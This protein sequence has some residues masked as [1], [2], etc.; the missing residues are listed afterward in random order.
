MT[1]PQR[2]LGRMIAFVVVV[3]LIAGALV[4]ELKSAFLANAALNGVILGVLILGIAYIIRQVILLR[5]EVDW[6]ETYRRN[7]PGLSVQ[8]SP[9]LLAPMAAML[10]ERAGRISLSAPSMRSLLD[11]ISSRMDESRDTSRYL[12]GLLIFLGLLGTFW[13]LLETIGSI[14]TTVRNMSLSSG[15]FET[16]FADL[17][18]GL[19]APLSGMATAFSS[20]L[21]GL[22]GSLVLGFLDLQAG[23]AQNRFYMDLEE[24]LSS[25]TR[26]SSGGVGEGD[27]SVPAY[28]SALLEQTAD[29]LDSLQR[30]IGRGEDSRITA[31]STLLQLAEKLATLSDQMRTEQDLMVKLAESQMELKPV[32]GRLA[33]S[34]ELAADRGLDEMSRSHLKN[35]DVYVM[36]LLEET[37][38]GRKELVED[39]RSEIKLLTRTLAGMAEQQRRDR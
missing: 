33:Q 18:R 1:R 29:S 31:N 12:I 23:Q 4:G 39:V 24:W 28:V 16:L 6:I 35:L 25:I 21:F 3:I 8:K 10:G 38:Q 34:M 15:N 20:S 30:V 13:G 7:E 2:Y 22:A 17:Q 26:L 36:R 5:P 9:T 14:G 11:S 19:G 37:T 32:L 27:Q